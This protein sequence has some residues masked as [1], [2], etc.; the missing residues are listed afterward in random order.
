MSLNCLLELTPTRLERGTG[1]GPEGRLGLDETHDSV[2]FL[3][4]SYSFVFLVKI[5]LKM[6]V[7]SHLQ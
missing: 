5:T 6:L 7:E 4:V 3:Y 2:D 1:L